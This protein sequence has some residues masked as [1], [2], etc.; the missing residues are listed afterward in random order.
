MKRSATVA[1][2]ALIGAHAAAASVPGA[3]LS[4]ERAEQL[5]RISS[6]PYITAA[7]R[8]GTNMVCRWTNGAR[9]WATTQAVQQAVGKPAKNVWRDRVEKAEKEKAEIL[10][11]FKA[12]A[13][14]SGTPKKTDLQAVID[15][16]E[17][18]AAKAAGKA[19]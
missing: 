11:D 12:V 5:R 14:K 2:L 7:E 4:K 6:R 18:K 10:E 13:A 16:H 17:A 3:W 9:E 1:V 19:Q 15:K 8:Q